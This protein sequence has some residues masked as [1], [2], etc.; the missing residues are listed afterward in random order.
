MNQCLQVDHGLLPNPPVLSIHDH[1]AILLEAI[2]P[3]ELKQC[4]CRYV[5][6]HVDVVVMLLLVL[7]LNLGQDTDCPA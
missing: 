4:R 2:Y 1:L 6:G 5:T 3:I 7:G